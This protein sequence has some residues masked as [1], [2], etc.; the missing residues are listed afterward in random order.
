M[1]FN[2][3]ARVN[4]SKVSRRGRRGA[5]I[6]GGGIGVV[7]VVFLISQLTGVNL[8]GFIGDGGSDTTGEAIENCQTG[9]DAN[10][11]IDCRIAGAAL[12]LDAYWADQVG[13]G[14]FSHK[15]Q[16]FEAQTDT[17]CGA[18]S[19]AT[20]PFYCPADENIYID[21]SFFEELRTTYGS[22]GGPLAEM[23]VLAHEWGHH[24]QHLVGTTDG[25]DLT[26]TGPKSDSV[27][28][29]L[30]AD[31]YAGAWAGD[32]S[33]IAD[34]SGTIFLDPITDAQVKDALSAAAAVG[35]D[36]IQQ[37]SGGG[38]NQDSWTHGSSAARQQWFLT[39]YNGD[40]NDCDTFA[41]GAL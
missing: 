10:A 17:G 22:S 1:T 35:D 7:I 37:S 18:A 25:L 5:A 41:R 28:L 32:A 31:C 16:L 13:N 38:V 2:D 34:D 23:Y 12:S 6:G 3:D 26:D 24:I 11:S 4:S 14:Y 39:G 33:T 19:S 30:Q 21:T 8:S 36:R 40:P 15:V 9:A 20:G 29:E 27:R